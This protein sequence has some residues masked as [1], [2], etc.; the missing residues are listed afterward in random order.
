MVSLQVM[1]TA[2]FYDLVEECLSQ[3]I[4]ARGKITELEET[5]RQLRHEL[6]EAQQ[7]VHTC[8]N[9]GKS[10]KWLA[11]DSRCG[12]CTRYTPEEIRGEIL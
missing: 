8:Y 5:N 7:V 6:D 12:D 4:S 9:C 2:S 10:V 11:P 1:R 3:L